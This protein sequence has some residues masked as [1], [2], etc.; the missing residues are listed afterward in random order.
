MKTTII[1]NATEL[2]SYE[3]PEKT[4]S[5]TP[6]SHFEL[7]NNIL[8]IGKETLGLDPI[9]SQFELARKGQQ[10]FG[11]LSYAVP[12]YEKERMT[13]GYR[14][15][16]DKSLSVGLCAGAQV[17][18]CSN[19]MFVGDIVTHRKHTTH[20]FDELDDKIYEVYNNARK[21][22]LTLLNNKEQMIEKEISDDDAAYVVGDTIFKN[23]LNPNQINIV[24]DE[25]KNSKVFTD[26]NVWSLYNAYTEAYKK[27]HPHN[28]LNRHRKLHKY[29]TETFEIQD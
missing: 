3:L 6:V 4:E 25:W 15:S 10:M 17:I 22:F 24:K 13:I 27:N 23:I 19:L 12:G 11:T 2:L 14:N 26:R 29:F 8:R 9:V 1:N 5:Y 18:V 7:Y 16:Y 28:S 21:N 20:I